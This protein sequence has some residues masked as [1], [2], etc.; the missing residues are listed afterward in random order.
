VRPSRCRCFRQ[1]AGRNGA[2]TEGTRA[3]T[4]CWD[5]C[6]KQVATRRSTYSQSVMSGMTSRPTSASLTGPLWHQC[7]EAISIV[8]SSG[9][10]QRSTCSRKIAAA[11]RAYLLDHEYTPRALAWS[12]L[13]GEDA[14]RVSL[15]ALPQT[16]Q[17][18]RRSSRSP[19]S[20]RHTTPTRPTRSTDTAAGAGMT[21]TTTT[22]TTTSTAARATTTAST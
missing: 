13:K 19:T 10:A 16:G 11:A 2:L 7:P 22:K 5:I 20:R 18:A 1:Q 14:R 15:R 4:R 17:A 12:R 6:R 9:T 3:S 8:A 21:P